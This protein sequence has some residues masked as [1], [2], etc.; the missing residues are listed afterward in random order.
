MLVDF[1]IYA[2]IVKFKYQCLIIFFSIILSLDSEVIKNTR[3]HIMYI[4]W[5]VAISSRNAES[6]N[7]MTRHEIVRDKRLTG[8]IRSGRRHESKKTRRPPDTKYVT[9]KR[10]CTETQYGNGL[11]LP[12]PRCV[13]LRTCVFD[14]VALLL[15]AWLRVIIYYIT[16]A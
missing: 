6:Y 7:N 11:G 10:S 2:T 5:W 9:K 13:L 12:V 14:C 15:Y 1:R 4:V 3:H 16:S 8:G